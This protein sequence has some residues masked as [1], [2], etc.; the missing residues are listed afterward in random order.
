MVWV[1]PKGANRGYAY[2]YLDGVKVATVNLYASSAQYRKVV[3]VRGGLNPTVSH[4]LRV[5]V[6]GTKP[7][8]S[9]GTRVDV[10]AFVVLR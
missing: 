2:V 6:P 4:T 10:D 9:G 8:A 3:F 5:Y 1:A 7:T